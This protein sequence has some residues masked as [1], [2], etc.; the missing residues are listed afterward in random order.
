[1][2]RHNNTIL[3]I[4]YKY[5][6]RQETLEKTGVV[7]QNYENQV[8]GWTRRVLSGQNYTTFFSSNIVNFGD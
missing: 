3:I 5:K 7:W 1:M 2:K 8:G 4:N 6:T